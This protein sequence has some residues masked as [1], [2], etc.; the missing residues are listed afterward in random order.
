MVVYG[1]AE[2]EEEEEEEKKKKKKRRRRRRGGERRR[3]RKDEED[4][5]YSKKKKSATK[6]RYMLWALLQAQRCGSPSAVQHSVT[7]PESVAADAQQPLRP[8]GTQVTE[9]SGDRI[10]GVKFLKKK[11]RTPMQKDASY[12]T[13]PAKGNDA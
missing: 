13:V 7:T 3:R 12:C 6:Q 9:D 1:D 10:G 2:E 5:Q 4:E 8:T 11:K